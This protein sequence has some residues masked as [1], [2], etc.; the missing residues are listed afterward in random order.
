MSS[1]PSNPFTTVLAA[2]NS[3]GVRYLVISGQACLHYGAIEATRDADLWVEL[4][5]ENLERLTVALEQLGAKQRFL[6]PL[7]RGFLDRGHATHFMV[8]TEAG[9][10]RVDIM[11]R[12]PRVGS[13]ADAWRD[14]VTV[15]VE[16]VEFRVLDIARLVNIKK[17]QR[18]RDYDVICRLLEPLFEY[19]VEHP[20]QQKQMGPWLA[21]ELRS[22]EYLLAMAVTWGEGEALLKASGRRACQIAAEHP[23]AHDAQDENVVDAIRQELRLEQQALEDQ[24]RAYWRERLA[25]LR[26]LR[27]A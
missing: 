19:A 10:Y 16:G 5:D 13:F 7:E 3:G 24:D 9:E 23:D 12:P 17:T 27:R 21:R 4:T 25:E 11:C 1:S 20:E 2:L 8:P 22:P 15:T 18:P 14:S 26:Q 6:P